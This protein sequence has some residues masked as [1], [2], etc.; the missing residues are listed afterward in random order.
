MK[1]LTSALTILAVGMVMTSVAT[2]QD[3]DAIKQA[4]LEHFA[5]LTAGN[6]AA[7]VAHHMPAVSSFDADG[8][9]LSE[10]E[11]R[12][13]QHMV[14]Q[15]DLDGGLRLNLELRHLNVNVYG[16]AAVVTGYVVGTVTLSDGSTLPVNDRRTAVLI[17]H[18]GEWKEVHTHTSNLTTSQQGQA[19]EAEGVKTMTPEALS[20]QP[21]EGDPEA[22]ITVLYG[23]PDEAG[24]FVVRFKLPPSW[25]SRPHTHG[26]TELVTFRSGMCY[27]AHGD[28]L[29]REAAKKLSP[30][31]FIAMPAGTKMRGFTGDD[32]CVVG[33]Q[34][35]GPL[36]TQYLDGQGN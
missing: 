36:T 16:D 29:T 35:Q 17:R 18:G 4:T 10:A 2:A 24:H 15:A 19:T 12:E 23:N 8:G 14:L 22:R 11:S 34:G 32:G 20:W 5:T 30:G 31:A 1:R 25:A 28:A 3:V 26:G 9:L 6:A 7:H 21:V 33:V 27:I 13:A